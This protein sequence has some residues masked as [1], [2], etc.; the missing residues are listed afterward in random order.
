[1]SPSLAFPVWYATVWWHIWQRI[2]GGRETV[3][4]KRREVELLI[5]CHDAS[6]AGLAPEGLRTRRNAAMCGWWGRVM[7]FMVMRSAAGLT[8]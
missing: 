5:A 6:P 3:P 1:M 4:G 2:T 8:T 7:V